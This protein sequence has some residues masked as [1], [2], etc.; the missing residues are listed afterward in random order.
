MTKCSHNTKSSDIFIMMMMVQ[1]NDFDIHEPI[2]T[3][4][5]DSLT[6]RIGS[7]TMWNKKNPEEDL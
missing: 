6:Q 1:V 5:D 3:I 2:T 4:N 7:L